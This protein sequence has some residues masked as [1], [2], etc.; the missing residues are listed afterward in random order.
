MSN[1]ESCQKYS[2]QKI[3]VTNVLKLVLKISLTKDQRKK[4]FCFHMNHLSS[5]VL[6]MMR[7]LHSKLDL[8]KQGNNKK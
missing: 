1:Q 6:R 2:F 8:S 4:Y 3:S 5:Y 7:D